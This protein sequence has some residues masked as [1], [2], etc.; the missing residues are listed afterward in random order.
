MCSSSLGQSDLTASFPS[1]CTLLIV[2]KTL[3]CVTDNRI[4]DVNIV[5]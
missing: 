1:T 2:V 3:V 4:K 5:K